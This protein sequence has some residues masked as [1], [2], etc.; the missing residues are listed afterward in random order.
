MTEWLQQA[1]CR[2]GTQASQLPWLDHAPPRGAIKLML[3][4]CASCPVKAQCVDELERHGD[5]VGVRGGTN[6][7]VRGSRNGT[8]RR[9]VHQRTCRWCGVVFDPADR[10]VICCSDLCDRK[11]EQHEKRVCA[12]CRGPMPVGAR[13]ERRFCGPDC[14]QKAQ[15][16]WAREPLR[17]K[18][19]PKPVPSTVVKIGQASRRV[20]DRRRAAAAEQAR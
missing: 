16:H 1:A 17:R 20:A 6:W 8:K 7:S 12:Q 19:R 4:V 9:R 18:Q 11:W 15:Q 5:H 2:P 10:T 14:R 3:E 13:K